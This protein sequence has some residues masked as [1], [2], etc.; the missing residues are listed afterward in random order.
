MIRISWLLKNLQK[1]TMTTLSA[2]LHF[3][4]QGPDQLK[5]HPGCLLCDTNKAR[6]SHNPRLWE[7]VQQGKIRSITY[8]VRGILFHF[9]LK[10]NV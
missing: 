8:I 1:I 2:E 10:K 7:Y 4:L 6:N 9:L 5:Q 3:I